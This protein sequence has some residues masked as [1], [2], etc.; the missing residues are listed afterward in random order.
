[1]TIQHRELRA[2]PA[3]RVLLVFALMLLISGG[4]FAPALAQSSGN[5]SY[6]VITDV[7]GITIEPDLATSNTY[8]ISLAPG[9]GN[10]GFRMDGNLYHV[11]K[12]WAFALLSDTGDLNANPD[13]VSPQNKWDYFEE[14]SDNPQH[15]NTP[16]FVSGFEDN[17][18]SDALLPGGTPLTFVFRSD[19]PTQDAFGLHVTTTEKF[20]DTNGYTGFVRLIPE[21]AMLQLAAL[22]AMGALGLLRRRSR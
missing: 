16:D 8:T 5:P 10:A 22:S 13:P 15:P 3:G 20:G 7:F 17:D 1:M 4:C 11:E 14:K 12:I 2:P 19:I 6:H 18:K 9:V 21:P